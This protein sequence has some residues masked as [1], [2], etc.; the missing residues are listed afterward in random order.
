MG[1]N[2]TIFK[3]EDKEYRT[4]S[5]WTSYEDY[6]L[7]VY[8]E[9]HNILFELKGKIASNIWSVILNQ[10]GF[11]YSCG[12]DQDARRP[13]DLE[14]KQ[15][16]CEHSFQYTGHSEYYDIDRRVHIIQCVKCGLEAE[17]IIE[18]SDN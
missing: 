5:T 4:K 9:N 3:V 14:T 2:E 15:K 13:E 7:R 10:F 8:D 17:E 1:F 6:K 18:E 11:T 16:Y 12:E